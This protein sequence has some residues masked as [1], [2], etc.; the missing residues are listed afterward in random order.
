MTESDQEAAPARGKGAR[1]WLW[2][3]AGAVGLVA[4]YAAA[5]FALLPWLIKTRLPEITQRE[6][7]HRASV[8]EVKFNPF[9][10]VFEAS[11]ARLDEPDG[12]LI[13]G[14]KSLELDLEWS[15]LFQRTWRLAQVRVVAPRAN[16]GIS[17]EGAFNLADLI[18]ALN[19]NP[20]K[21]PQPM[22]RL[23]VDRFELTGG[24][25]EFNDRRAGYS[26]VFT[27]IEFSVSDFSTLPDHKGPYT[28]SASTARGGSIRWKGHA[29]LEPIAGGGEV[30]IDGLSLSDMA[31]YAKPFID[32]TVASGKFGA[33][34]PYRFAYA[35][36]KLSF[37]LEKAVLKVADVDAR[38]GPSGA[39]S[40]Q[41]ALLEVDTVDASLVKQGFTVRGIKLG[42]LAMRPA[43]AK[44]AGLKLSAVTLGNI[45]GNAASGEIMVESANLSGGGLAM[46]RD[47]R[48]QIDL[49]EFPV[50][51][52][53]AAPP[54]A[55]PG[56]PSMAAADPPAAVAQPW[57]VGVKQVGLDNF[58]LSINDQSAP[59]P[60]Q[61][62]V[63]KVALNFALEVAPAKAGLNTVVSGAEFSARDIVAN[64]KSEAPLRIGEIGAGGGK[65]D[66]SAGSLVVERAW[67]KKADLKLVVDAGGRLNLQD[68]VPGAGSAPAAAAKPGTAPFKVGVKSL[69]I[70]G[71]NADLED[72]GSG[73]RLGVLEAGA[74]LS[75][76][77][78]N[79]GDPLDFDAG[80]RLREGG[81]VR[82]KGRV[83]PS[84]AS[85]DAAVKV[86][87]LALAP[88]QTL[89][90]RYIKLVLASGSVS[91]DG[92][93]QLGGKGA[94]VRYTG[95]VGLAD[96][97]LN[98]EGGKQFAALK[99][100]SAEG[101]AFQLGPNSLEVP[102][103]RLDAPQAQ[104]LIEA[105]RSL[106]AVRLLVQPANP[107]APASGTA[108]VPAAADSATVREPAQA[109]TATA[110]VASTA[111][112]D[113]FPVAVRRLR[114]NNA[115]LDF[116]DLSLRP[117]FG[118][119]I[120]ELTGVITGLSTS[121]STRSR[122]ELD[123]RVDE[124][125]LA[126]IRGEFNPFFPRNNTAVN[127][128]FRNVDMT[129]ATP[130]AMKFAGYKIA[131]GKISLD[132]NYKVRNSQLEGDNQV[133]IDQLTLG[134]RVDSPDAL[135]L[136]LELAIAILKDSNG[137]IDLGLPVSGSLDDPQFSYGAVIWKAVVNVLT[138]IVTAPF[139]ALGAL[140][141]GDG[142][143]LE[144]IDFDPGSA[145]ILPPEREKLRQVAQ[146]LAK[147]E[148]LKLAI[149][150]Q[151]NEEADAPVLRENAMRREILGRAGIKLVEG[152]APGP[153]DIGDKTQRTA[154]REAFNARHGAPALEKLQEEVEQRATTARAPEAGPRPE[155]VAAWRRAIGVVQGEPNLRLPGA[156]YNTLVQRLAASQS[157]PPDALTSLAGARA[158][159]IAAALK[160][161]GVDA[162]RVTQAGA[163]KTE[164]RGK[165]V[166][167]KLGLASR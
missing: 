128:V 24:Q 138:R 49:L 16:L 145:A 7:G 118:A 9:K 50:T 143:K 20:P 29:S 48:G 92:K 96:L 33:T 159:A 72:R 62:D 32:V 82:A 56:A 87:R 85:V 105:D 17:K 39:P 135:K 26:N 161:E 22:P 19:R 109:T 35:A 156:Y 106:N 27:P 44:D 36:G 111:A 121:P 139:R 110:A 148:Q 69:E 38:L 59:K 100:A 116:E 42:G 126:R 14:L 112:P 158:A 21:E 113:P 165:M 123:G 93:L 133:V 101:I 115:K 81:E 141:G 70:A 122:L 136:P 164:I 127:L 65:L 15:S 67:L 34:L 144:A 137:R 51:A 74:K 90:A 1:R 75:G 88:L 52:K 40:V 41:L 146:V 142:A 60:L 11:D 37:D 18:A 5:G 152:E 77:S 53:V 150:G 58:S 71:I 6:I 46:R 166:P 98:E 119:K 30:L 155:P 95:N 125:G 151:Y 124:F 108:V 63:G 130:Y 79:H 107:T 47:A 120:H 147:R 12:S 86:D 4:L 45:A 2:L 57:K 132:L 97:L 94:Q 23:L 129:T 13:F 10:L 78:S 73:I 31:T 55:Q 99:A 104:L 3:F 68:M 103:L 163:E 66:L 154:L 153:I 76:V 114:I 54:K 131:S 61:I 43:N 140:F 134:E 162:M 89:M 149:P 84:L 167:L 28:F 64:G 83:L 25:V 102:E 80:F 8:G 160:E 91:A 117:Q 157:L